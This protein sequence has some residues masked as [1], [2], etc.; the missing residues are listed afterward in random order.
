MRP[1]KSKISLTL[2]LRAL[3]EKCSL[4]HLGIAVRT[5]RAIRHDIRI[6]VMQ[7][8]T[9][10]RK[11]LLRLRGKQHAIGSAQDPVLGRNPVQ[12]FLDVLQRKGMFEVW[13]EHAVSKHDVR[14]IACQ[15]SPRRISA[16]LPK[17]IHHHAVEPMPVISQPGQQL[18]VEP[19]GCAGRPKRVD[20]KSNIV[21]VWCRRVVECDNLAGVADGPVTQ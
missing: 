12:P 18:G 14:C 8:E 3:R 21:K 15:R 17:S 2:C 10:L 20:R 4:L 11:P 19:I 16:V 6:P 5:A 13:V 1:R 9:L 7:P